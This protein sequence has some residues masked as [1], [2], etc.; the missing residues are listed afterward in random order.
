VQR[1]DRP[2]EPFTDTQPSAGHAPP[3]SL[4][5]PTTSVGSAA[6]SSAL[7]VIATTSERFLS[8]VG[9]GVSGKTLS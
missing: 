8:P 3:T 5:S 4:H 6:A 7:T 9:S 1:K 2:H